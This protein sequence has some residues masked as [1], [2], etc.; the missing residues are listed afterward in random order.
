MLSP[1]SLQGQAGPE[2]D[3]DL[4]SVDAKSATD[5][6]VTDSAVPSQSDPASSSDLA[7]STDLADGIDKPELTSIR[8]GFWYK[9]STGFVWVSPEVAAEW[10]MHGFPA[11]W[12]ELHA[13]IKGL[14]AESSATKQNPPA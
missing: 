12:F 1:A 5:S 8:L 14:L 13:I 7:D 2:K 9:T 6:S 3:S 10:V 4:P 11:S